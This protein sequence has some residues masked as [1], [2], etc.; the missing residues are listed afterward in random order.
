[1][2]HL[3]S[4]PGS[5]RMLIQNRFLNRQARSLFRRTSFGK[6]YIDNCWVQPGHFYSPV[7]AR[8]EVLQALAGRP[9]EADT[10]I[11][12]LNLDPDAQLALV[13]SLRQDLAARGFTAEFVRARFGVNPQFSTCD[14]LLLAGMI[15]HARPRRIVEIGSGYST[16]V[17]CACVR[18]FGLDTTRVTTLDPHAEALLARLLPER[19]A[20]L[21][22]IFK[23][24]QQ[25]G[26][27]PFE[28]LAA[29]DILFIDSSHVCKTGSDVCHLLFAILPRLPPGVLVH[30]HDIFYPFEY[31]VPWIL[32]ENRGWNELYVVRA[33]LQ[34][35]TAFQILAF[36][37][38]LSH[39]SNQSAATPWSF[40]SRT[41]PG[42]SL[43]IRKAG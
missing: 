18:L 2:A 24:V 8:E 21:D 17:M 10:R 9:P 28:D 43:W 25:A 3:T 37:A 35:N 31:P 29:N 39:P 4:I 30:I 32:Q 14:S 38:F 1:M 23:P 42:Q 12:D 20:F 27:A 7:P 36:A 22:A 6:P 34:F 13:E 19:P 26:P 11:D 40:F 41:D 33:F 16:Q 5:R 15:H